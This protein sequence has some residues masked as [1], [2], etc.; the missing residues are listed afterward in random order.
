MPTVS[1][2]HRRAHFGDRTR[3]PSSLFA[4]PQSTY[5]SD[6]SKDQGGGRCLSILALLTMRL[7][8]RYAIRF[9]IKPVAGYRTLAGAA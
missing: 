6:R 8:S 4:C 7:A 5:G 1:A 9:V 3:R 2:S